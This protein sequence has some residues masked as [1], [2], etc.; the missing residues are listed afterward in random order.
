NVR[1]F[2]CTMLAAC[3]IISRP[4]PQSCAANEWL[5]NELT[6]KY[7]RRIG[8]NEK[9]FTPSRNAASCAPSAFAGGLRVRKYARAVPAT[10]RRVR[11]EFLSQAQSQDFSPSAAE[12]GLRI[13]H[14]LDGSAPNSAPSGRHRRPTSDT[15]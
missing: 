6:N 9:S 8:R 10:L 15:T 3:A 1:G 14:R 7:G 12:T 2:N 11:P 13:V 4:I 5:S